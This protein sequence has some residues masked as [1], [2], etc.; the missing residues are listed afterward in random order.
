MCRFLSEIVAGL[1]SSS[2]QSMLL[3]VRP[4]T[5][6]GLPVPASSRAST[7]VRLG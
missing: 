2:A 5:R 4:S 6:Q 3:C 1:E 7:A